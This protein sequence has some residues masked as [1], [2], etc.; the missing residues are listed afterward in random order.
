MLWELLDVQQFVEVKGISERKRRPYI[1][2]V[3][4][5][6]RTLDEVVQPY[7]TMVLIGLCFG[8]RISEILGLRWTD[9]DVKRS[10]VLIQRSAVGKRL[11]RLKTGGFARRSS[12]GKGLHSCFEEMASSLR[13]NRTTVGLPECGNGT[14]VLRR[15]DSRRLP[16]SDRSPIGAWQDRV[17]HVPAHLL[18]LAGRNLSTCGRA[19]ET[20]ATRAHFNNDGPVWKCLGDGEA[21]GQSANCATTNA[22]VCQSAALDSINKGN[23]EA[24]PLIR[25]FGQSLDLNTCP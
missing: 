1:L 25:Q 19:A 3:R 7:R 12:P 6:W 20:H 4:D 15:F 13:S 11:N 23:C 24:V 22:K 9:F 16:C 10:V 18:R 2:Q 14:A 5:A 17:P 21:Q 8:L